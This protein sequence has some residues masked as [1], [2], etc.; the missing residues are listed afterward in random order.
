MS[1]KSWLYRNHYYMLPSG[2]YYIRS[3][4]FIQAFALSNDLLF[5]RSPTFARDPRKARKE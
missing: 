5:E 1:K 3:A 4:G 2:I